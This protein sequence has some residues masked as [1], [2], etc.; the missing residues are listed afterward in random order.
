[1]LIDND[2]IPAIIVGLS[3][4]ELSSSIP[5]LRGL[6]EDLNGLYQVLLHAPALFVANGKGKLGRRVTRGRRL[7]IA[8]KLHRRHGGLESNAARDDVHEDSG[9]TVKV[10]GSLGGDGR[11]R[12]TAFSGL[13]GSPL[14]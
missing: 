9:Y 12:L 14:P 8:S 6:H 2:T 4:L 3:E 5:V 7:F 1:M 11:R 13:R 10:I